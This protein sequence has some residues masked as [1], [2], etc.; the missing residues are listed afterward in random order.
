MYFI[1]IIFRLL[2]S[3]WLLG[4]WSKMVLL[5][6]LWR[7]TNFMDVHSSERN[8][9][10]EELWFGL[11]M[12]LLTKFLICLGIKLVM[13]RVTS[14][15]H[16]YIFIFYI[17]ICRCVCIY[18]C[19]WSDKTWKFWSVL[20]YLLLTELVLLGFFWLLVWWINYPHQE[21]NLDTPEINFFLFFPF[22]YTA[23][24]QFPWPAIPDQQSWMKG[25]SR[26]EHQVYTESLQQLDLMMMSALEISFALRYN[27]ITIM[28]FSGSVCWDHQSCGW[29][30]K[31]CKSLFLFSLPSH[32]SLSLNTKYILENI[33]YYTSL[34]TVKTKCK[35]T[36]PSNLQVLKIFLKACKQF[37]SLP[38]CYNAFSYKEITR[39]Q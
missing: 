37:R 3:S 8:M 38:I 19:N 18:G 14:W 29:G 30:A 27:L 17:H 12:S 23:F 24:C 36:L 31:I 35:H 28:K 15:L 2:H 39:A 5:L 33:L 4:C 21:K 6:L 7:V 22:K 16:L 26:L 11:H 34:E 13:L 9:V 1:S 20:A 25:K 10:Q 32:S